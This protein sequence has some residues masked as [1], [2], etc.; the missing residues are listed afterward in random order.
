MI[1]K[2]LNSLDRRDYLRMRR[3]M[4]RRATRM[5]RPRKRMSQV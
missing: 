1:L 4:R 2:T 3:L 5:E